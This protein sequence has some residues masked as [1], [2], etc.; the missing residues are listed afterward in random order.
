MVLV[1]IRDGSGMIPRPSGRS[2]TRL[3]WPPRRWSFRLATSPTGSSR[4][5][6][7]VGTYWASTRGIPPR[8]SRPSRQTRRSQI[9][10]F[11][12]QMFEGAPEV[13]IWEGAGWNAW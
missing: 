13:T 7:T 2:T 8:L 9:Q 10:E 4:N 1:T 5:L 3:P 11:F 6:G 12:A